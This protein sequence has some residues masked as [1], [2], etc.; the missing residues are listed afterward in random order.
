[1]ADGIPNREML[2]ANGEGLLRDHRCLFLSGTYALR[3]SLLLRVGAFDER[4]RLG[5]NTDLGFRVVA[6]LT[7]VR[8]VI[9]LRRSTVD[10]VEPRPEADGPARPGA[11][12]ECRAHAREVRR[13]TRGDARSGGC[14]R[15]DRCGQRSAARLRPASHAG[16]QHERCVCGPNEAASWTTAG[17]CFVP[18]LDR[19]WSRPSP[20]PAAQPIVQPRSASPLPRVSVLMPVFNGGERI[21]RA[22]DS[23]LGQ[24]FADL[25]ARRRRR[26][27]DRPDGRRTVGP[28][29]RPAPASR[30]A[31]GER[32]ARG[33]TE[34]R[35]LALP[36]RADRPPRRGRLGSA[37][38][39]GTPGGRVRCATQSSCCARRR[40]SAS[41]RAG[42]LSEQGYLHQRTR[43][44]PIA[45]LARQPAAPLH[46]DV[47]ARCGDQRRWLRPEVVSRRGLRPLAAAAG[48]RRVPRTGHHGGLVHGESRRDLGTAIR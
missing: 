40:T 20:R 5:E 16:T 48:G 42:D 37:N 4:L 44:W 27:L 2:P 10:H 24:T 29:R 35:A 26:R 15:T 46:D 13:R 41:I 19:H 14:S 30:A 6:A 28:R 21:G 12:R 3:R 31:R 9:C 47:P 1:M 7:N 33:V 23:I 22:V 39:I 45:M 32:R 38:T 11:A 36:R 17:G 43:R 18:V 25:R 34:P 8:N